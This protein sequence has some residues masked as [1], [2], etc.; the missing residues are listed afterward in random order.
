M[1][2]YIERSRKMFTKPSPQ[3]LWISLLI[4]LPS[5][6]NTSHFPTSKTSLPKN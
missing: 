4:R 1:R 6:P 5:C 2:L 3:L